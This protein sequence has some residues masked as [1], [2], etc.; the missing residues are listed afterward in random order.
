V[1][2]LV[3]IHGGGW[4]SGHG[5]ISLY[6]PEYLLEHDVVVVTG[7]Y[8]LGPL[9]FLSTEDGECPGNF[10]FKDQTMM[11]SW[12]RMNIDKF[13]GDSGSVTLFGHSAGDCRF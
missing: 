4:I 12:V 10:G 3:F 7:N 8:R 2:V 1:P 6:S 9:G 11:L 5:G 13:G